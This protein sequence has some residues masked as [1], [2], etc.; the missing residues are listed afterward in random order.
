MFRRRTEPTP[1]VPA[2]TSPCI[3]CTLRG[4][5][6]FGHKYCDKQYQMRCH[7]SPRTFLARLGGVIL[8]SPKV[9]W[10]WNYEDADILSCRHRVGVEPLVPLPRSEGAVE[11]SAEDEISKTG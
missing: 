5:N 2:A 1:A 3:G 11:T 9:R 8:R 6:P 7:E 4:T 10:P